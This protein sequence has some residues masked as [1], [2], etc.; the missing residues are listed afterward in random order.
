M[1]FLGI[2]NSEVEG[3]GLFE[4]HLSDIGVDFDSFPAFTGFPLPPHEGY[5]AILVGGTPI[6][7]Y[8]VEDHHFLIAEERYL[9]SALRVGKPCLGICFGGQLI[10]KILGADVR[11][12]KRKE[13]GVYELELTS[14][15][16]AESLLEAFPVRFP[17]FQWH[18]DT[19]DIPPGGELLVTG[20]DCPNQM[21]RSGTAIGVQF[22]LEITSDEVE[23][24]TSAYSDELHQFGKTSRELV[25]E[26]QARE[27]QL[28]ELAGR[29]L[30][31]FVK[32][33]KSIRAT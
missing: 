17:A 26:I 31:N 10:A 21:F 22:H 2:Q 16:N 30:D 27:Q 32:W 14:A 33:A 5:D 18:G 8:A 12:A 25:V 6:S 13:I 20:V 7:A 9:Q 23:S 11:K 29:F 15:G 28:T 19:F 3:F 4:T 1:R 24:W